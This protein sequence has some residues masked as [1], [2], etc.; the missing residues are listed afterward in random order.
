MI[1]QGHISSSLTDLARSLTHT[2]VQLTHCSSV[3]CAFASWQRVSF[4]SLF[5]EK[6]FTK[7][8]LY[9]RDSVREECHL[10]RPLLQNTASMGTSSSCQTQHRHLPHQ[11]PVFTVS[12]DTSME[13]TRPCHTPLYR[14]LLVC[15]FLSLGSGDDVGGLQGNTFIFSFSLSLFLQDFSSSFGLHFFDY[16]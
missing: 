3:L 1:F 12:P 14:C 6:V 4:L 13:G 11:R 15:L 16:N 10:G 9:T 2:F 5:S 7:C 8:P